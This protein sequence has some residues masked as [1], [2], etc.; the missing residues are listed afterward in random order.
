MKNDLTDVLEI[1]SF[2]RNKFREKSFQKII[3]DVNRN[4]ISPEQFAEV[5]VVIR[6][7]QQIEKIKDKYPALVIKEPD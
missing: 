4:Q 5:S 2:V 3:D 7:L 1:Q 6:S